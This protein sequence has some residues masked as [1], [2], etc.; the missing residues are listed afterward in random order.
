MPH[1]I[2]TDFKYSQIYLFPFFYFQLTFYTVSL[3]QH[4]VDSFL[5]AFYIIYG[6]RSGFT[7]FF[8]ASYFSYLLC[9][10]ISLFLTLSGLSAFYNSIL[11]IFFIFSL[12]MK[13]FLSIYHS[14]D[15]SIS[16]GVLSDR[17]TWWLRTRTPGSDGPGFGSR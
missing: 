1:N 3:K 12:L 13:T 16:Q 8:Y 4:I 7:I 6:F 2:A 14:A 11:F 5:L 9:F 10:L 17:G 15:I